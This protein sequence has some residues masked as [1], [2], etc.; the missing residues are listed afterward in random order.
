MQYTLQNPKPVWDKNFKIL[1]AKAPALKTDNG[2]KQL[3]EE[4]SFG[5]RL[6][7]LTKTICV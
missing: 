6:V 1:G 7:G 2:G 3:L 5:I 4:Y